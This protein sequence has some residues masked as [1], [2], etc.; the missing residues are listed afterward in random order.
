VDNTDNEGH[1]PVSSANGLDASATGEQLPGCDPSVKPAGLHKGRLFPTSTVFIHK[2]VIS[3]VAQNMQATT[4]NFSVI[5]FKT[6]SY[7]I[8]L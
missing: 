2:C 5:C 3:N 4:N 8:N 7:S 6:N 1:P